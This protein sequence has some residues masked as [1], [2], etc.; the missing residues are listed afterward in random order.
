MTSRSPFRPKTFYDS[1]I[2]FG[3]RS[4][5]AGAA[6]CP[7]AIPLRHLPHPLLPA[8]SS[9][10][11]GGRARGCSRPTGGCWLPSSRPAQLLLRVADGHA[12][13]RRDSPVCSAAGKEK[14]PSA[15]SSSSPSLAAGV[16]AGCPW[17]PP[18]PQQAC[19]AAEPAA[20]QINR[21]AIILL[22]Q[23]CPAV[24]AAKP[25]SFGSEVGGPLC[26]RENLYL[27]HPLL[28]PL[29]PSPSLLPYVK[30]PAPC[31]GSQLGFLGQGC[32]VYG[33][34]R[35]LGA[36]R[37]SRRVGPWALSAPCLCPALPG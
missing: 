25:S 3:T 10:A 11:L 17:V 23:L 32:R 26:Q 19:R 24:L 13:P 14:P 9:A 12:G 27:P 8:R 35:L 16:G 21:F 20:L 37:G 28:P 1:M 18:P 7:P 22:F 15:P 6:A 2:V 30:P 5:A 4:A 29:P 36:L 33:A 31:V 34:G